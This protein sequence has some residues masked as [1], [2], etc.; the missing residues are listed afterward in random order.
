[1]TT[2][3]DRPHRA[4]LVIDVQVDVVHDAYQREEVIANVVTLV[5]KARALGEPVVWV[6]HNDEGMPLG[7]EVWQLVPELT[8]Q[9]G[10]P[11][12]DKQ[13][14]SSFIDTD[15]EATLAALGVGAL[16][17]CGAQTN[18]CV[19]H[20]LHSALDFGYDVTLVEDAHTTSDFQWD[21]G[22]I[23]AARIID[24]QNASSLNYALPGRTCT[25]TTTAEAFSEAE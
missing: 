9:P 11:L 17:I 7:S 15:L 24:E 6:Q 4:L 5:D 13:Y 18:N 25:L 2:F 1:M 10:E 22:M 21:T 19:R 8:P 14:R 23:S 3:T 12:I 16:M 20:T